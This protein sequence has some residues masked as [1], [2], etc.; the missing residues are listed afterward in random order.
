[1]NLLVRNL[2]EK[3]TEAKLMAL[4]QPFGEVRSASIVT[5]QVTG[6]SR[7]F[8][9]VEMANEAEAEA[10][11]K[12]LHHKN[13]DHQKIRVKQANPKYGPEYFAGG[14][15][16]ETEVKQLVPSQPAQPSPEKREDRVPRPVPEKYKKP[17]KPFPKREGARQGFPPRGE[18]G[19]RSP[20][21]G[22]R[23]DRPYK[24]FPKREDRKSV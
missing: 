7:G 17:Y 6:M 16:P 13:I 10:A 3:I 23:S 11:I 9:F 14:N 12:A 5:D 8:G 15:V 20:R 2:S 1:M 4:F 21:P 19:Y 24:P 22:G 18:G